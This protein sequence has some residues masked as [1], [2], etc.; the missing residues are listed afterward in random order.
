MRVR[1]GEAVGSTARYQPERIER[2]TRPSRPSEID[3]STGPEGGWDVPLDTLYD[4]LRNKRRRLVLHYLVSVPDN[5]AVL[6]TLATQV[7]AWENEIP[8][9]AVTSTLRKRTYN[10]LQQTHLPKMHEA[11]IIDYDRPRGT[12]TL[13]AHPSQLELFLHILPR[14]N[15][16]WTKGFLFSGFV[17]WS[18]LAANWVFVHVLNLYKPG[19]GATLTALA[20]FLVLLGFIHVYRLFR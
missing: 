6:G 11:D 19:A 15:S 14:T 7:A 12:V 2:E 17:L 9:S 5:Q 20:L 18:I 3:A 8:L 13:T 10:T 16:M 4:I 1:E